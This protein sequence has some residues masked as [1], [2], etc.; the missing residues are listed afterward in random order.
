MQNAAPLPSF[1]GAYREV[2]ARK[3]VSEISCHET[4]ATT[5]HNILGMRCFGETGK[6]SKAMDLRSQMM[7]QLRECKFQTPFQAE[8]CVT[9]SITSSFC[10]N[11]TTRHDK[12]RKDVYCGNPSEE[13]NAYRASRTDDAAAVISARFAT[14]SIKQASCGEN[15]SS[16]GVFVRS[17]EFAEASGVSPPVYRSKEME[18][19]NPNRAEETEDSST[20]IK[21]TS[22]SASEQEGKVSTTSSGTKRS[23][24]SDVS[25]KVRS[26]KEKLGER[27]I[28]LQQLICPFGK[29][30]KFLYVIHR[31]ALSTKQ[32]DRKHNP[33]Y[34]QIQR[35]CCNKSKDT[36]IFCK[37]R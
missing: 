29:V 19:D 15:L 10:N 3:A 16:Q 4:L 36:L 31:K 5:Q 1:S 33:S 7:L 17:Q 30:N 9:P 18:H 12:D 27:V 14:S 23:R 13:L 26:K 2:A 8:N 20:D 21:R 6:A 25:S 32:T 34:R 22:S 24:N 28:A 37:T 11:N 35:P